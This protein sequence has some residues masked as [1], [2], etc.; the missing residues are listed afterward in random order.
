MNKRIKAFIL[1]ISVIITSFQISF[2]TLLDVSASETLGSVA[3]CKVIGDKV[4]I[5][6]SIKHSILVSN[7]ESSIAVYKLSPWENVEDAISSTEPLKLTKMSISFD[8]E[9]PC[10][11]IS[12]K[13]SLYAVALIA[14]DGSVSPI[15]S[16]QYPDAITADTSEIGFK[17]VKTDNTAVALASHAGSAIVDIYLDKLDN[18]NKSGHI[19]NADGDIFY[20]DRELIKR[21]DKQILSYTAMGC[22]V[23]L[24]FLISPTQTNIPFCSDGRIWSTNKCVVVNDHDALNAIYGYTYFL[25]SRYDGGEYGKVNGI[26]L[27]RGTDMPILYNYASLVSADYDTVYARSLA[28]IG[29]AAV[30]ASGDEQVSLVVPVGDSLTE[31]GDIYAERFLSSV[32]DYIA[33]HSKLTFTVMCE[34]THNPYHINDLMFSADIATD[35]T[36]EDGEEIVV[37]ETELSPAETTQQ[38]FESEPSNVDGITAYNDTTEEHTRYETT[39]Y[40]TETETSP[41]SVFPEE[42][43]AFVYTSDVFNETSPAEKPKPEINTKDDGYYCT[44]TLNLFSDSFAKLKKKYRSLNKNF[45][46]CWYPDEDTLEGAL[47]VCYSYNYMKLASEGV[48]FFAVAFE[49]AAYDRF[50]SISHLFKYIDTSRN[51]KETEYTRKIL[52]IKDWSEIIEGHVSSTGVYNVFHESELQPNISDYIGNLLYMNYSDAH[53][54][55]DWYEGIY[56]NSIVHQNENGVGYLLA[57]LGLSEAGLNQA[58]IGYMFKTPEPLLLG[59]ALTFD[60]QCGENDGSLYEIAVY[61]NCGSSTVVSDTVIAGG[62]RSSLSVDVS[63]IYNASAV[64]S[65]R[66]S[67]TRITGTGDCKLKLYGVTINSKTLDDEGLGKNF[68]SIRDYLRSD[69]DADSSNRIRQVLVATILLSS[70]AMFSV[71]FALANDRRLLKHINTDDKTQRYKRN[72]I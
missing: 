31:K 63:E 8:F 13:T 62:V 50:Q 64:R 38:I 15:A 6:G 20:F 14:P 37:P 22:E 56:C 45:A 19:F 9:L 24:R 1:L 21:L 51:I 55:S 26:I 66:I 47:G 53:V 46:W 39:D 48:D 16:P 35:E 11:T 25:M 23:L 10:L 34:S 5:S 58:E 3:E 33:S 65:I 61:I 28:L 57:D 68:S 17:G 70:V 60:I 54:I 49:G 7:R 44:D 40:Q 32:A 29:L 71:L 52:E 30:N 59:D 18:G 72:K 41:D 42:S 67:L 69:A 2:L 43:S 12:D 4:L 36:G 27:G